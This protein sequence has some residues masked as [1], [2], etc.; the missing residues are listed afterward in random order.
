MK[1]LKATDYPPFFQIYIDKATESTITEALEKGKEEFLSLLETISETKGNWKYEEKKWTIKEL[2]LHILDTERVM[3]FRALAFAR[4]DKTNLPGFSEDDYA[5]NSKAN[6]RTL[7]SI[8]EEYKT[9]RETTLSLFNSFDEE[10]LNTI[11]TSNGGRMS[12][13]ALGFMI[14]GHQK[15]H[16]EILK[17]RYL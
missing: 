16:L 9:L 12:V 3:S 7:K 1:H 15:H 2:C 11:G 14:D 8:I 4:N 6:E 13:R 10:T 17:E 5:A